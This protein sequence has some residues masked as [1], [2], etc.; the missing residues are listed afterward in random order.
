MAPGAIYGSRSAW[1][2]APT[3]AATTTLLANQIPHPTQEHRQ[4]GLDH[5]I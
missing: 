3:A 2:P 1:L 4:I 5:E